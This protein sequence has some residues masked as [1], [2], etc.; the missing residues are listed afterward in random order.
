MT[1]SILPNLLLLAACDPLTAEPPPALMASL[2][3]DAIEF[4][5]ACASNFLGITVTKTPS[6]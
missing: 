2:E 6:T 3:A 4:T 5:G 1:P